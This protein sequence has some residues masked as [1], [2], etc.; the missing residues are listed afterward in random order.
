MDRARVSIEE[1]LYRE[2]DEDG[3]KKIIFN[4]AWDKT[5]D[6]RDVKRGVVIKDN[7]GRLITERK[8]S[9]TTYLPNQIERTKLTLR[10]LL[11]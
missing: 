5:E 2:L 10:G 11:L 6:G 4:M 9:Q 3:V 1:E 8:P 7:N